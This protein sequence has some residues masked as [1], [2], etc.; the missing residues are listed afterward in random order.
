[1]TRVLTSLIT[2]T[3][4]IAALVIALQAQDVQ[5]FPDKEIEVIVNYGAGGSTDLSTRVLVE[6]AGKILGQPLRV[7]NRAGGSG[8]VGPTFITKAKPNGYT[9]GVASFSPLAVAPH[10][11]EVPYSLDDFRFIIGHA[12]YRSGIAVSSESP[13]QTMK[14]LIEAGRAG[15]ELNYAATDVLGAIT[16]L[17]L[18]KQT[19]AKFKWIR[20]KSGQEAATATLGGFVDL[21]I[22]NPTSITPQVKTG[23]FRMLASA[24]SVR[25]Y[26]LPEVLTLKEQGYDVEVESYAGLAAPAG[27]SDEVVKTLEDAFAKALASEEVQKSLK[28]LG[29]E[30]VY[31]TSAE[32]E[33]LLREGHAAMGEDLPNVIDKGN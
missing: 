7:V 18:S 9:I 16:M 23:K 13:Y 2:G 15:E 22:G 3:F 6:A 19:G 25:W 33:T 4:T 12:R 28:D 27:T 11:Q 5:A 29:M 14:D 1:M 10:M 26:E 17:R 30:P 24:S 20:Y 21:F 8:T 32:Y 31:M